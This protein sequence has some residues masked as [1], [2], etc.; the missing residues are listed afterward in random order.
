MLLM[1][2]LQIF[3]FTSLP[4][5]NVSRLVWVSTSPIKSNSHHFQSCRNRRCLKEDFQ[6]EVATLIPLIFLKQSLKT[7]L[8]FIES[9]DPNVSSEERDVDSVFGAVLPKR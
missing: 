9:T 3:S 8:G 5:A 6:D 1:S 2:D 4:L 7:S